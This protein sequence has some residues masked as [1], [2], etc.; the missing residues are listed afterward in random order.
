MDSRLQE[1]H[2]VEGFVFRLRFDDGLEGELDLHES[3][4][5]SPSGDLCPIEIIKDFQFDKNA[6][7]LIWP[8]GATVEAESLHKYLLFEVAFSPTKYCPRCGAE[9]LLPIVYGLP[10]PE[11]F[12]RASLGEVSLGGCVVF[13]TDPGWLC[14]DC[15][16]RFDYPRTA[17][18][19]PSPR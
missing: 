4:L 3:F 7:K 9:K 16:N 11:L 18:P 8:G 14:S 19:N 5:E 12:E 17:K 2:H 15:G 6:Q 1:A 13:G 10:T